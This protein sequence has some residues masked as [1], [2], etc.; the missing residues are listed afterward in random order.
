MPKIADPMIV[1]CGLHRAKMT[2]AML[3]QPKAS[4]LR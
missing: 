1:R 4:R 3:S 2:S